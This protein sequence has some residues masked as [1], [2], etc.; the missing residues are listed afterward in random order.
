MKDKIYKVICKQNFKTLLAEVKKQ[1]GS[2][3]IRADYAQISD[4]A[5]ITALAGAAKKN[6]TI[7]TLRNKSEGGKFSGSEEKRLSLLSY[8]LKQNFYYVDIELAAAKK[9]S[10]T[11]AEKKK[12]I[13]SYHNFKKTPLPAEL[14]KI[15]KE[16]LAFSPAVMK[17][18][19]FAGSAGGILTVTRFLIDTI[20]ERRQIIVTAMGE[21]AAFTRIFFPL[22]GSH[23]A[24]APSD[25][26]TAPGQYSVKDLEKI[27][28]SLKVKI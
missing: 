26:A 13:L 24:Y 7:F 20:K 12:L 18:A 23:A 6:K 22:L 28:N 1:N 9:M 25:A 11:A 2:I 17:V 27:Y 14:N 19:V 15:K 5:Q 10:F 4:E 3:E 16:M 21:K 8:A